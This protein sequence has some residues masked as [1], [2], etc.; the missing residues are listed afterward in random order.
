MVLSHSIAEH[1]R[2]GKN[3]RPNIE[4]VTK[5]LFKRLGQTKCQT[6]YEVKF[7]S[8]IERLVKDK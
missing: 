3:R 4:Y 5:E 2:T 7:P 6:K 1:R 8:A